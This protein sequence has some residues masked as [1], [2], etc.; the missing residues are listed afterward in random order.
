VED[1]EEVAI[2]SLRS[3]DTVSGAVALATP[4]QTLPDG[5][6]EECLPWGEHQGKSLRE[7]GFKK[8]E[9]AV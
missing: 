8:G 1:A 9:N 2:R 7:L 5:W 3:P 6:D 4:L